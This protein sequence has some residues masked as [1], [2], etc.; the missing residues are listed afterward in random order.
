MRWEDERYVRVYTRDTATWKLL[1]WEGKAV[2]ALLFRKVDRA[3]LAELGEN[4]SEGLAALLD[5]PVEIAEAGLASVLARKVAM[6][7]GIE[8]T[9]LLIP[10]FL[11]AQEAFT[12][13]A[14]RKRDQ[15]ER[16]A[17]QRTLVEVSRSVTDGH[18]TGQNVTGGHSASREVTGGH[19]DPSLA[20]PSKESAPAAPPPLSLESQD[21]KPKPK[22]VRKPKPEVDPPPFKLDDGLA[23]LAK[24]GR[25]VVTPMTKGARINAY[26]IVRQ[27]PDIGNWTL[28]GEW[29][30]AGAEDWRKVIDCRHLSEVPAWITHAQIWANGGRGPVKTSGARASPELPRPQPPRYDDIAG[31]YHDEDTCRTD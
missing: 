2:L 22:R 12:N 9:T 30:A 21:A 19:S 4:R 16:A 1:S 6:L 5:I 18:A 29:L 24:P 25:F 20:V 14:Q 23:E 3:G 17:A 28:V 11:A 10:N 8:Q 13:D 26:A 27:C 31:R 7:V 15:R